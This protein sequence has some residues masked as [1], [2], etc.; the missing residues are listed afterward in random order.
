MK[1]LSK[2][3]LENVSNIY[4][5]IFDDEDDIMSS[6]D[7]SIYDNLLNRADSPLKQSFQ[8][9]ELN[10]IHRD[11]KG[12]YK[13]GELGLYTKLK[14]SDGKPI[15]SFFPDAN[16][17]TC[18]SLMNEMRSGVIS[19]DTLAPVVNCTCFRGSLMTGFKDIVFNISNY[20]TIF[21]KFELHIGTD[22]RATVGNLKPSFK[23]EYQLGNKV[24]FD[25]VTI[26]YQKDLPS[27]FKTMV[28]NI[29]PMPVFKNVK[30]NIENIIFYSMSIDDYAEA[31]DKIFQWPMKS[32]LN[33]TGK[34]EQEITIKN[35]KKLRA[36]LNNTKKY[37][38]INDQVFK[39]KPGA[40]LT[41]VIDISNLKDLKMVLIHD[42]DTCIRFLKTPQAF[43]FSQIMVR[44]SEVK[45]DDGWY[46]YVEKY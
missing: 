35:L 28:L 27:V 20:N 4:E 10:R 36:I 13:N 5:S 29:D 11:Y 3:L 44:G 24:I 33:V 17:L 25:N 40:K 7:N 12:Y 15:Q 45:T 32:V 43:T 16:E 6:T 39:L 19:K 1:N 22:I 34:G 8:N 23:V 42:N 18:F 41:D 38:V 30:G 14:H 31:I 26:N 46:V 2:Y 21:K 37:T 9:N